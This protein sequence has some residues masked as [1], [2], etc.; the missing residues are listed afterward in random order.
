MNN[1]KALKISLILL[2]V[3]IVFIGISYIVFHF[4]GPS[5]FES[6]SKTAR[7]PLVSNMFA[8]FSTLNLFGSLVFLLMGII[9][10]K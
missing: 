10:N 9:D 3:G 2:I 6:F 5:G 8:I 7:K 4:V 1:K